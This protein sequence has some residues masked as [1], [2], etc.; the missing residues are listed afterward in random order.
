MFWT[1]GILNQELSTMWAK[2]YHQG[3]WP[4]GTHQTRGY[5]VLLVISK[6][7]AHFN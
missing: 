5:E 6:D 1:N 2:N 7:I 3:T 4:I